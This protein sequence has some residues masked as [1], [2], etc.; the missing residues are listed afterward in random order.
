MQTLVLLSAIVGLSLACPAQR[1]LA[2]KHGTIAGD[3]FGASVASAGD[4]DGD[5]QGDWIVGADGNGGTPTLGNARVFSGRDGRQLY[6]VQGPQASSFFGHAVAGVGDLDGDGRDDFAVGAPHDGYGVVSIFSGRTGSRVAAIA[7]PS[8]LDGA[9][10]GTAMAT[11]GDIDGDTVTDFVVCGSPGAY[12]IS[13]A[14]RQS[15]RSFAA[16]SNVFCTIAAVGDVSGDGKPEFLVTGTWTGT[17]AQVL[18]YSPLSATPL[19][20]WQRSLTEWPN[21]G[22]SLGGGGDLDGDGVPDLLIG[23]TL[24]PSSL[25]VVGVV[26]AFSGADGHE[27]F[28]LPTLAGNTDGAQSCTIV[29]DLN[30]DGRPDIVVGTRAIQFHSGRDGRLLSSLDTRVES[31]APSIAVLPD[32]DGDG[33][34]DF[35]LGYPDDSDPLSLSGS[36]QVISTRILARVWALGESCG[37][38]ALLPRLNATRPV[39]GANATISGLDTPS[40]AVGTLFIGPLLA[41]SFP[42]ALAECRVWV[43]IG[44]AVLVPL[45]STPTWQM[46]L[47]IPAIPALAGFELGMQ[48]VWAPTTAVLG[49]DLTNAVGM[50]LGN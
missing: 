6:R 32:Q 48:A 28:Q 8:R 20:T 4:I 2:I 22:A 13:G 37:H 24:R 10:F 35:V 17:T 19:R 3:Y 1:S 23:D 25:G 50:R 14:T 21:F 47:P 27:L 36:A 45:P 16:G 12:L 11:L 40:G 9:D 29:D 18:L 49:F 38:A 15:I 30:G 46:P 26:V 42:L 44:L 5:G 34:R 31:G 43:D 33:L 7:S 41:R 39:L